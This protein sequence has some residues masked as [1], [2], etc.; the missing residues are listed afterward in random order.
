MKDLA[1]WKFVSTKLKAE[2]AIGWIQ[3]LEHAGSSPGR[4]G[5]RM[6]VA[7]DGSMF[8]SVG[9]GIMEHKLVEWVRSKLQLG[10]DFAEFKRQ[11]HSKE[12]TKDQSGMICSG[13]QLLWLQKFKKL[14]IQKVDSIIS[15][16]EFGENPTLILSPSDWW[17]TKQKSQDN[18]IDFAFSQNDWKYKEKLG[19]KHFAHVV[20]GGHVGLE[21]CKVLSNLDYYVCNYD[22][23]EGLN[24]FEAN[25]YA[26]R[27]I[28]TEYDQLGNYIKPDVNNDVIIM[29]FGYRGDDIAIRALIESDFRY[30]GMMGS[31][32]KVATLLQ[33]L[34]N[35]G[36]SESRIARIK[37]P[38]GL[39][40]HCQTPAEIAI[41]IAAEMIACR[42]KD[43]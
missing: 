22:D 40:K 1:F 2:T 36:I 7:S 23:R 28:V 15:M 24:T 39:V 4:Q 33:G 9:G 11:I 20:G 34:R 38:A 37:T 32:S 42:S 5:F 6:A 27:K 16:L 8:G 12:A 19:P 17:L 13:E 29:T 30:L 18:S 3:V 26:N 41:S 43:S 25:P 31:E 35:D 10:H 21:M 14:D